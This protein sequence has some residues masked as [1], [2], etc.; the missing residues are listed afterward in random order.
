MGI[1]FLHPPKHSLNKASVAER[2]VR[3]IRTRTARIL[4]A[5]RKLAPFTAVQRAVDAHNSE[6]N[7]VIGMKP[8]D[9]SQEDSGRVLSRIINRR[10][11]EQ[12]GFGGIR[13]P[14]FRVGQLVRR[15]LFNAK[16]FRKSNEPQWD[17]ELYIISDIIFTEPLYSYKIR[18]QS[19]DKS[20]HDSYSETDLLAYQTTNKE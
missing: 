8:N 17:N 7:N 9:V 12:A 19:S 1:Q 11:K 2:A 15:K 20:L 10:R 18:K 4:K 16:M 3:T 6:Y 14:R 13:A 5:N